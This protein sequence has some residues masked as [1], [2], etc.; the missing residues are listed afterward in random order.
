[1]KT[2]RGLP[3]KEMQFPLICAH[4]KTM[5]DTFVILDQ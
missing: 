5:T 3:Q 2:L 1:M 4:G